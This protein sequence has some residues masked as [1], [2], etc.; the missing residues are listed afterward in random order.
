MKQ[1]DYYGRL[2]ESLK[3]A[4]DHSRGD[5]SRVRVSVREL[6]IPEYTAGD[7]RSLRSSLNLS[8]RGFA[9]AM[10]VSTRTVESWEIGR[11]TPNGS[12]RNL[13]YLFIQNSTLVEQLIE[14][15]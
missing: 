2:T 8:Q 11:N 3:Q 7:V 9:Y 4:A 15:Q 6:K 14:R 13:L 10:G 12:A 5:K 1:Y